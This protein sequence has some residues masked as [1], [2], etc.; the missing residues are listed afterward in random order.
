MENWR[1]LNFGYGSYNSSLDLLYWG[2]GNPSPPFSGDR[3]PGDN[4]FTDSVVALDANSGKLVWY[5]QFT[6]HDEHD[7]DSAQTPIL[8]DVLIK[9]VNRKV[10][11][12]PN[13]NGFYYVLDRITGEFLS[14]VPFVEQNWAKGLTATGHPIP[15]EHSEISAAGRLISPGAIGGMN[16]QPAAFDPRRGLVFVPAVESAS[17]FTKSDPDN[18][19]RGKTGMLLGS[20]GSVAEP[21]RLVVR[22]LNVTTGERKWEYSAGREKLQDHSGLL[23]TAGG[24]VF[25]ASG[26]A[27]F[28]LNSDTGHELWRVALALGEFTMAAPITFSLDGQQEVAVLAGTALIVFGL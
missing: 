14:G 1:R 6:P 24:L 22:A 17:V 15:L 20:G 10:I 18:I 8:A 26:G 7:W 9:G 13:R 23:A 4:L 3:R 19:V 25:G 27:L 5:F 12:W 2:V 28:A 16:W 21:P 11:C